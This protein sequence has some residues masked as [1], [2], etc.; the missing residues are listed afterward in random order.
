LLQ[1]TSIEPNKLQNKSQV[2][3]HPL[4][5]VDIESIQKQL[6]NRNALRGCMRDH[7][8]TADS[9]AQPLYLR[10]FAFRCQC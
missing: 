6:I 1:A 9:Q 4:F 8:N 10:S 2:P 5:M 7:P 3:H